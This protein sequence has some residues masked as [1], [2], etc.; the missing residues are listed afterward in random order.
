MSNIFPL[1][2][3]LICRYVIS[4][5][6]FRYAFTYVKLIPTNRVSENTFSDKEVIYINVSFLSIMTIKDNG[7]IIE[8]TDNPKLFLSHIQE[9]LPLRLTRQFLQNYNFIATEIII[10]VKL[11]L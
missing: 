2:H 6:Y 7:A 5:N 1:V 3:R 11:V 9:T 10:F 8:I 4:Q